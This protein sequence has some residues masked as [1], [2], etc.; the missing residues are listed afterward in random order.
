MLTEDKTQHFLS[1]RTMTFPL[2]L[3]LVVG[4]HVDEADGALGNGVV[5]VVECRQDAGEVTQRGDLVAQLGLRAE[6][7]HRR[8]GNRLQGFTLEVKCREN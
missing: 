2:Q 5:L 7:T 8:R 6:Q 1:E 3:H 4:E